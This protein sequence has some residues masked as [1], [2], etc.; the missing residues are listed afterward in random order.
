MKNKNDETP[1]EETQKPEEAEEQLDT[2]VEDLVQKIA[3]CEA[4]YKRALADYQ[5]L[6]KRVADQRIDLIRGANKDL[7]LRL[8]PVLDTL[9]LAEQH[10][11]DKTIVISI[12]HFLDILKSEGVTR[13]KTVGEAFDPVIMEAIATVDGDEGKVINETRAGFMLH[14][15]LLRAAQ[16]T[17]GS[18]K[19]N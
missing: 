8:L 14:E 10:A 9:I 2:E 16:V 15:K 6:E 19:Q 7:L 13:I 4:K 1:L 12:N 5:N 11:T 3:E 18:A 17:V